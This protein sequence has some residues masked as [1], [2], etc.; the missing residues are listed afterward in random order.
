MRHLKNMNTVQAYG[1]K[2]G[3]WSLKLDSWGILTASDRSTNSLNGKII[4]K[5]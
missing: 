5:K 3:K 2:F 4:I 1:F